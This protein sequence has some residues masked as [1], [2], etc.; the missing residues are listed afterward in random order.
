MHM[1]GTAPYLAARMVLPRA[2]RLPP[3][4]LQGDAS[5]VSFRRGRFTVA[6]G[7]RGIHLMALAEAA[8]DP[9]NLPT[10]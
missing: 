2:A 5:E 8:R 3:H 9:G 7:E 4:L 6:G 10:E 1:G